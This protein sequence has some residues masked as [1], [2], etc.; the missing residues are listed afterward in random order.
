MTSASRNPSP[1]RLLALTVAASLTALGLWRCSQ[2]PPNIQIWGAYSTNLE[3]LGDTCAVADGNGCFLS[4][5]GGAYPLGLTSMTLGVY[6]NG[7]TAVMYRG[8][9]PQLDG[10]Q[11]GDRFEF[12]ISD[13]GATLC[14]CAAS[15]TETFWGQYFP[16]AVSSAA[17]GGPGDGGVAGSQAGLTVPSI[18]GGCG[19][20]PELMA[21]DWVTG[22]DAVTNLGAEYASFEGIAVDDIRPVGDAS[23][24]TCTLPCKVTYLVTGHL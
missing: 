11:A 3:L 20:D 8:Q 6:N 12:V 19:T 13:A 14:G 16:Q 18:P 24:C 7:R 10:Q 2:Y 5:D 22:S 17:D 1:K 15:I 4:S 23:A 9:D 21:G